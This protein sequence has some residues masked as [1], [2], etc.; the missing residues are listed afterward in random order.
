MPSS[1]ERFLNLA[2]VLASATIVGSAVVRG[3]SLSDRGNAPQPAQSAK[4]QAQYVAGDRL[5][6]LGPVDYAKSAKTIV[7]FIGTHCQFCINNM[8]F[9]RA[10]AADRK[11][12]AF[13]LIVAGPEPAGTLNAFLRQY[14]LDVDGVVS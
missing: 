9:Y 2:I 4:R 5:P 7:L 8:E 6:P 10:L 12:S 11:S 1:T 13:Q 3:L 14:S